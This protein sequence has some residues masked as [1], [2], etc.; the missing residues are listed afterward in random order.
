[1]NL[2][3]GKSTGQAA[4]SKN[5]SEDE[6]QAGWLFQLE[7][8]KLPQKTG[9]NKKAIV[10]TFAQKDP[11]LIHLKFLKKKKERKISLDSVKKKD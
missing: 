11:P 1:M 2:K 4:R 5:L 9:K 10:I 8:T 3:R 7:S 6:K